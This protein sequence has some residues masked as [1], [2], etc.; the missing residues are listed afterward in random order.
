MDGAIL[1][2]DT[3]TID[4]NSLCIHR[5][6]SSSP[7]QDSGLGSS[8]ENSS[9]SSQ[10]SHQATAPDTSTSAVSGSDISAEDAANKAKSISPSDHT[11]A[12]TPPPATLQSSVSHSGTQRPEA[13][14]VRATP[15]LPFGANSPQIK[16]TPRISSWRKFKR[17]L[18]AGR[19]ITIARDL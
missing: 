8:L 1:F 4:Q 16:P 6:L 7:F 5:T 13:S 15:P 11:N 2:G 12:T 10:T 18:L 19:K 3:S 17:K 14:S 9:E